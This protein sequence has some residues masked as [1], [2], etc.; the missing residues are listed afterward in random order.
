MEKI[1]SIMHTLVSDQTTE[2]QQ[3]SGIFEK[4]YFSDYLALNRTI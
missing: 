4:Y 1:K 3:I 2:M